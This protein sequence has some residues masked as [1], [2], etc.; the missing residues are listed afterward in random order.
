[1]GS[2]SFLAPDHEYP[3]HIELTLTAIDS[4]GLTAKQTLLLDPRA[5]ELSIDSNP[6]G[7]ELGAGV[8]AGQPA[9]IDLT[10][11]SGAQVALSAP[12]SVTIDGR[13]YFWRSWSDGGSREH[14]V[15]ADTSQTITALFTPE[16]HQLTITPAGNGSGSVS[17]DPAGIDCGSTCSASFDHGTEVLL[18]GTPDPGSEAVLWSGCDQ[19]TGGGECEVEI[20]AARAVTAT[21]T[22]EKHELP[23]PEIPRPPIPAATISTHP[24][25]QTKSSV[26]HF[27]FF[28]S[29]AGNGFLCRLDSGPLKACRSPRTF[30]HLKPRRHSFIVIPV[31][32]DGSAGDLARFS[33]RV[34]PKG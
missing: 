31:A 22:L 13:E 15:L 19:V 24:A 9:P 2:G 4:R 33:W 10:V 5:V 20:D 21:F 17:S 23:T 32:P 11:I 28:S 30:R 18:S 1:V 34:K 8:V 27:T 3:S 6:P 29:Q 14:T 7:V 16:Q 12:A 25:K 26:A